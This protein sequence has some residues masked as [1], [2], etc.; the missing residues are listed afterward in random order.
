MVANARGSCP[1]GLEIGDY[2]RHAGHRVRVSRARRRAGRDGVGKARI[3]SNRTPGLVCKGK[4]ST[5]NKGIVSV[6]SKNRAVLDKVAGI[7]RRDARSVDCISGTPICR[8]G[9]IDSVEGLDILGQINVQL[10]VSD[11]ISLVQLALV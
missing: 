5:V 10:T 9:S 3:N 11:A 6:K 4:G 7:P 8:R 1:R 2:G